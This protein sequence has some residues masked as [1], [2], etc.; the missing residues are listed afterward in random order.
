MLLLTCAC[1]DAS[2]QRISEILNKPLN[3]DYVVIN[4]QRHGISSLLYRSLSRSEDADL[5]PE[6]VMKH[7]RGQYYATISRNMRLY[8]E[9]CKILPS[10][11][12]AGIDVIVLKGAALAET[13]YH[14][15]GMRGFNDVDILVKKDD[16]QK[17]KKIAQAA[18]YN[19]DE[20]ISPETYNEKF[21]CDL[22]YI[23]NVILE[24]HWGIARKTGNDRFAKIEIDELWKNAT[25]AKIANVDTLVL[26]PEDMLL[27]L[28]IHLPRHRYNRLIWFCDISEIIRQHDIKWNYVLKNAEKYRTKA[29]LYYGLRFTSELLGAEVP[30]Y[31]LHELKPNRFETKLFCSI[32]RDMVP[33]NKKNVLQINPLLKL[34]LVDRA[35]DRLKFLCA[36]FF[37]H[38]ES[39]ERMYSV[40]RKR[41][42]FY[43]IYHP[44]IIA[45]K[46]ARRLVAFAASI[47]KL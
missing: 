46:S 4:A 42:Y 1:T 23:K 45:F 3:W 47:V 31:V 20:R 5:V 34:L 33:I 28:C 44:L 32:P 37:P 2:T 40:S 25:F 15:I 27:H 17:A 6:R 36:Y 16:L 26:S 30:E 43:Y 24:I 9:L 12:D 21:G 11:R 39:L 14:D 13:V 19:L 8:D 35:R 10:Y 29:Y 38:V 41:V 18:G 22:H 7:L